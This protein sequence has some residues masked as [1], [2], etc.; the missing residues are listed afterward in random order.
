MNFFRLVPVILSFLLLGAHFYRTGN[1]ALTGFCIGVMFLLFVRKP[2]V[3]RFFQGLLLLG[4][5]EWL[6]SLY[7][8]VAMRIA[9]DQPWTRLAVILGAVALF[10]LLSGLVFELRK[11][12]R[13]YR[14]E[15]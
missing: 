12:R 3:P 15:P 8:F 13:F 7:F 14:R 6:R 11:P 10:T 4:A 5:F 9:W 2:W 1:L